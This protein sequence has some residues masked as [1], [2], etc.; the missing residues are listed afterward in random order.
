MLNDGHLKKF[1]AAQTGFCIVWP[2]F[3]AELAVVASDTVR[4]KWTKNDQDL[5]QNR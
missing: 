1:V 5:G 2:I 4:K 3:C